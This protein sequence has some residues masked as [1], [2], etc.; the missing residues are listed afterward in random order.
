MYSYVVGTDVVSLQVHRN[1]WKGRWNENWM[2]ICV[3]WYIMIAD[4]AF[5]ANKGN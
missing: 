2:C 1:S 4:R 5:D 3:F